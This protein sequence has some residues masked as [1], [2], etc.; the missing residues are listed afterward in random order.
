LRSEEGPGSADVPIDGWSRLIPEIELFNFT[1]GHL[2]TI[3]RNVSE[4]GK[5]I[6]LCLDGSRDA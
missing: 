2:S 1:G 6:Q 4:I 3:T 5:R